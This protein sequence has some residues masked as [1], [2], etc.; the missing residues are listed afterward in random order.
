MADLQQQAGNYVSGN[1]YAEKAL[2]YAESLGDIYR[3]AQCISI[4]G[5]SSMCLGDF[6]PAIELFSEAKELLELCGLRDGGLYV[7][8]ENNM[9]E[10][11][12][13]KTEY[14]EA[15]SM[16]TQILSTGR[17]MRP[18]SIAF[19]HINM[20]MVET[21]MGG[22]SIQIHKH[23]NTS[24]QLFQAIGL[25]PGKLYCDMALADLHLRDGDTESAKKIFIDSVTSGQ[26]MMSE[27]TLTFCLERLA[28]MG[29]RMGTLPDTLRWA[30]AFLSHSIKSESRLATMKALRCLGII[31][32][33]LGDDVTAHNLF[34]VALDGF[35]SMGVHRWTADCM[36]H[37]AGLDNR[38]GQGIKSMEL[39]KGA[40]PPFERSSQAKAV[41][42]VNEKLH[43]VSTKDL[44]PDE[45]KFAHLTLMSVKIGGQTGKTGDGI[46]AV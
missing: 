24:R 18:G 45:A 6:T 13:L 5:I 25:P 27:D 16:L 10:V 26:Q 40:Q 38:Q 11:H 3:Q 8:L 23:I 37:M 14:S 39:R 7:V 19:A 21:A 28:D 34:V 12:H 15:A 41:D 4:Q 35:T 30:G 22:D 43:S 33:S 42:E 36:V 31:F 20:A 46:E 29:N 32:V 9:A 2:A 17:P 44:E 1:L